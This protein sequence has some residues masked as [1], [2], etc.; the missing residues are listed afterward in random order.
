MKKY[1]IAMLLTFACSILLHAQNTNVSGKVVDSETKEALAG[2]TVKIVSSGKGVVTD[3]DGNFFLNVDGA[4]KLSIQYLGFDE[5][6]VTVQPGTDI[7]VELVNSFQLEDVIIEATRAGENTPVTY[8][9]VSKKEIEDQNY[10]QDLP[11]LL[12]WT[13]S[14]VTTS[15]AG[16][17]VG[18][19]GLRIRGSDAT[20]INVTINGVPVNDS[21]SHGV[22]WVNMPDLASSIDNIQIQRGVGTST[23]GAAAF[24]ATV[25]LQTDLPSKEASAEVN[26]SF[27][28]FNTRKHTFIVNSGLIN[29]KWAFQG[30]LSQIAS[31]GYIDRARS[32][33]QSYFLSGGYYG[34]NTVLK[35]LVFGGKEVT[36]QSWNG[37]PEA[38]LTNDQE[39][40][41]AVASNNGY[42]DEQR[43]NLFNS[44]RTFNFYLYD[45]EVDNYNQDHYQ[46]HLSQRLSENLTGNVSLHYT[47][48]RGYFEQFRD[49]DDL[50]DYNIDPIVIGGETI[51]ETDLIRR[52]WLD[53]DFY[54]LTYSLDLDLNEG[55]NILVG[56]AYNRYLGDHFGEVIWAQFAGDSNIRDRYYFSDATK[57][58]FNIYTKANISL[59][60]KINVFGDFQIRSIGYETKGDDNDGQLI[61]V[62]ESYFF[63]NPKAGATFQINDNSSAYFSYSVANREPVRNDFVDN[64]KNEIPE[65][66]VLNNIELGY[67]K[68]TSK[69]TLSANYYLMDYKNQLVLTGA[70]NDVGA[71]VRENV[72][73]SYRTG[74]ELQGSYNLANNLVLNA[75]ATFSRNKI[76]DF[77]ETIID[78]GPAFDQ[79]IVITNDYEDTD[80]AFSPNVIA[81][82]QLI[83]SPAKNINVAVLSKYVGKQFLDNTSND[84]RAI[85]AYF[86]TDLRMDI[87]FQSKVFKN[88]NLGLLVNNIFSTEYVSNGYTFGYFGGQDFEVRENYFYPQAPA[89]FLASLSLKF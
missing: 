41:E 44:G 43:A 37:T 24:G 50:A 14:L 60:D 28:S 8:N 73:D 68:V 45:N 31:D 82:G 1:F 42:S 10:G 23:N 36:Y 13:P 88:I 86:V 83:Y 35:A 21:E 34:K 25:S 76:G 72:A 78:F 54:G 15:D 39:G 75:N 27:G 19:T 12:K 67:R 30:R 66:E 29:D 61:D 79:N 3:L 63:F 48:G 11:F 5:Q 80:I 87:N 84:N 20:R 40:L 49:G 22:F 6:V 70:V 2:A 57:S 89:N 26:N 59:N 52:R 7:V 64:P 62:D 47:Y 71:N 18:Y 85:D 58:D 55:S 81:G 65:H 33:L 38:R 77:T 16:A 17:G 4:Q 56:G 74:I 46:L 32:D 9:N 69:Y 51:T 53:N